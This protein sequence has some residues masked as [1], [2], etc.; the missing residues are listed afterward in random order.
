[1][2]PTT[3][4]APIKGSVG[5]GFLAGFFGACLG[6]ALIYAVAKGAD[7]KKGAVIGFVVGVVLGALSNVIRYVVG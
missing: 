6:L 5:L 1:M 7:T 2:A 4:T 3:T